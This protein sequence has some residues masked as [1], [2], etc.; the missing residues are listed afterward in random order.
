MVGGGQRLLGP[1]SLSLMLSFRLG[2]RRHRRAARAAET[3]T[4]KK[5]GFSRVPKHDR[6]DATTSDEVLR[7]EQHASRRQ[8]EHSQ[9]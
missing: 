1:S 3:A 9:E 2:R 7:N 5:S 8:H 6:D 4:A